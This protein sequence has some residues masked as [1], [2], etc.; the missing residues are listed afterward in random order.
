MTNNKNIFIFLT[1]CKECNKL[2]KDCQEFFYKLLIKKLYIKDYIKDINICHK[3]IIRTKT[4]ILRGFVNIKIFLKRS[5]DKFNS[6]AGMQ[7]IN[8]CGSP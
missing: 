8:K 7:Q 1:G 3:H 5:Y 2:K 6:V 4:T